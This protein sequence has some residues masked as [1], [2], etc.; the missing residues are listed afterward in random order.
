MR[1]HDREG[2]F[3]LIL[4]IG[5]TAAL[6]ILAASLVMLLD[7]QL[8]GTYTERASKTSMYYAEAGLAS[9]VDNLKNNTAWLTSS[10]T[11]STS[12]LNQDY[13]S[14]P[15]S[16]TVTYKVYDD[17]NP[18]NTAINWDSN[19]D[20]EVWVQATTTYQGRT[21]CVRELVECGKA[22]TC[23]PYSAAWADKNITMSG[24]SYIYEVNPNGSAY[25]AGAPYPTTVMVGGNFTG[26]GSTYLG[27]SGGT[28]QTVGLQV[29][30][31]VSGVASS[32][33]HT[34]GG[35]GLLSDYFN[36]ADQFYLM[37][38][39][40][41]GTPWAGDTAPPNTITPTPKPTPTASPTNTSTA[42]PSP[43][44]TCISATP[45]A[46]PTAYT[47]SGDAQM[48]ANLTLT[49]TSSTVVTYNFKSLDVS[50]NLTL[51]GNV[52]LDCTSLYVG[53]NFTVSGA[54]VALTDQFGPLY[55]GGYINWKGGK[56]ST[57]PLV[58]IETTSPTTTTVAGPIWCRA[59]SA[60]AD[61]TNLAGGDS[62]N[63]VYDGSS[64]PYYLN[65]GKTWV[66]ANYGTLSPVIDFSGPSSGTYSTVMCPLLTTSDGTWSSGEVNF[67]TATQPMV[68]CMFCDNDN[69]YPH[70]T[71]WQSVG[72]YYGLMIS[73][74]AGFTIT[75]STIIGAVMNGCPDPSDQAIALSNATICYNQTII[76]AIGLNSLTTTS[77]N[78]VPGS[79]EQLSPSKVPS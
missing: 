4:L 63:E 73:F 74:E 72:T 59:I 60:D 78:V 58:T 3:S 34:T 79:W 36:T 46:S 24:S 33:T 12:A 37:Q 32:V 6:A 45:S 15:G 56:T 7:N 13:S 20:G 54:T 52:A 50:G 48:N 27:P 69:L 35:V 62:N 42:F 77:V 18:I 22:V 28:Q 70:T 61:P 71:T 25:T 8:H 55:V 19:G 2:G 44:P 57:S 66:N 1:N 75:N 29:D 67:G 38:E 9:A 76:N 23:L 30:G 21:S 10:Y 68:Y 5:I 47:A 51:S 16:P 53:G 26:T 11:M 17:L 14:L 41:S 65:I 43:L 40:Q 39:G 31:T 49:N 64:G